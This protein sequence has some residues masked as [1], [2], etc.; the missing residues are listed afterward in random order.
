MGLRSIRGL[1]YLG[2]LRLDLSGT[3]ERTV[4]LTHV[5]GC[6]VLLTTSGCLRRGRWRVSFQRFLIGL[7]GGR[8]DAGQSQR[9]SRIAAT[10]R[11]CGGRT[12]R[13]AGWRCRRCEV[14]SLAGAKSK[15]ALWMRSPRLLGRITALHPIRLPADAGSHTADDQQSCSVESKFLLEFPEDIDKSGNKPTICSP[16]S[17]RLTHV[18]RDAV[19]PRGALAGVGTAGHQV[20]FPFLTILAPLSPVIRSRITSP[21]MRELSPT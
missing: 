15:L 12:Y 18:F 4:N 19:R 8:A 5:G 13:W 21:I 7:A 3:G 6:W 10:Q 17:S 11:R 2:G 1:S 9:Y 16:A 14:S 20:P